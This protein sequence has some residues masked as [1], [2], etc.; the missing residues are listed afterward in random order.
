MTAAGNDGGSDPA[1]ALALFACDPIR[2][3]GIVLSGDGSV[4]DAMLAH[5]KTTLS[6]DRAW[7]RV[8]ANVD[9]ARLAAIDDFANDLHLARCNGSLQKQIGQGLAAKGSGCIGRNLTVDKL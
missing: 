6:G 9:I 2:L 3:G 5:L 4:R 8:P 1:L 7:V